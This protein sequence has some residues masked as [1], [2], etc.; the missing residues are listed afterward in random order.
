MPQRSAVA[1]RGARPTDQHA[2]DAS[3]VERVTQVAMLLATRG[4]PL[5][6]LALN[7]SRSGRRTEA[8]AELLDDAED[9]APRSAFTRTTT[10][11]ARAVNAVGTTIYDYSNGQYGIKPVDPKDLR[12]ARKEAEKK[13]RA[14]ARDAVPVTRSSRRGTWVLLGLGALVVAGGAAVVILQREQVRAATKQLLDQGRQTVR[15][16]QARR[17]ANE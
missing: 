16:L 8:E 6:R 15:Q 11:L 12:R 1:A 10:S 14:T 5:A 4:L 13:V 7:R 9:D 2:T 17:A 3:T